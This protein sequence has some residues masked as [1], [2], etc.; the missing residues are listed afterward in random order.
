[1]AFLIDITEERFKIPA[2]RAVIEY[3]R[4]ENP[5]AHSDI[6]G[7]L[8][9]LTKRIPNT[10]YY[11]PSFPSCA[12]VIAHTNANVIFAIALDM[13]SV[14]FRLPAASVTEAIANGSAKTSPIGDD[15]LSVVPL[16]KGLAASANETRLLDLCEAAHTYS[17][18]LDNDPS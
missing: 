13:L 17:K 10:H 7:L 4:R 6:G 15:W 12:Y 9:R 1:M 3:I 11:C 14:E 5:F 2:N 16:R 18:A 8:I